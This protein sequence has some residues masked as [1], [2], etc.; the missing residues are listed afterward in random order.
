MKKV[1]VWIESVAFKGYG[2]AR[3]HG[4]VVFIPHTVTGDQA[5]IEMTEE[6]EKYAVGRLTQITQPSPWRVDP[7]CTSFGSCGGCQ[8]QHIDYSIQCKLKKKI[9]EDALKRLG[10]LKK[11]PPITVIPSPQ[12]FGYRI[13]AQLKVQGKAMGYFQEKSHRIVDIQTCPIAHPLIN[14]MIPLIRKRFLPFS[15]MGEIEINVSSDEGRGV[16]FLPSLSS[17]RGSE[18]AF[19]EFLQNDALVKGIVIT[20]KERFHSF[21]DPTLNFTL[22]LGQ[23]REKGN[24]KFR[25]SP[26]SFFQ[27][28]PMQNQTLIQTVLQFAKANPLGRAL[29]LYCGIGNL[30]LPLAMGAK[31]VLGIEENRVAIKDARFNAER[32]GIGNCEFIQGRVEDVL[33]SWNREKPNLVVLDPPRRGCKTVLDQVARLKPQKVVYVSCEPTTFSRDLRLFQ[34]RGYSLQRLVLIDMFPQTYHIEVIGLLQPYS[35]VQGV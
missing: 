22:P 23:M 24:L 20:R 34:E 29:D 19:G 4:K 10:R 13:R 31:E 14:Q 7:L 28:N 16:L 21:G 27:V 5:W 1:Q 30:T 15:R 3:I 8:W 17:G 12:S 6:K 33:M 35:R 11:S 18:N 2:V 26:G 32:N 9:L 25:I